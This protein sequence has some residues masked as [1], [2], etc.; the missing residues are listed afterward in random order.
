M[1]ARGRARRE[2]SR[3]TRATGISGSTSPGQPKEK[4]QLQALAHAKA[5]RPPGARDCRVRS[6]R[7][8]IKQTTRRVTLKAFFS[9]R[10]TSTLSK[11]LRRD[12]SCEPGT[13]DQARLH[14]STSPTG[15][16][17][18]VTPRTSPRPRSSG[19]F[20][21]RRAFDS[22][23]AA[24]RSAWLIRDRPPRARRALRERAD[25]RRRDARGRRPRRPCRR[26]G[27]RESTCTQRSHRSRSVTA[28]WSH[29]ATARISQRE[30]DCRSR[31][32]RKQKPPRPRPALDRGLGRLREPDGPGEGRGVGRLP[33][34]ASSAKL[35]W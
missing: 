21:T 26:F 9:C 24:S 3:R 14:R 16:A 8:Q 1:A 13:A 33:V 20:A 10:N 32:S 25:R 6:G 17:T 15:W 19:R 23:A 4:A 29:S 11:M 2:R 18:W 12:P 30:S 5:T 22:V 31:R 34:W 27:R 35:S 7:S 28:S